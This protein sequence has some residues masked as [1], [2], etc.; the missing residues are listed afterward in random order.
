MIYS[1]PEANIERLNKKL[2]TIKNKCA[3][4]GCD[5]SWSE[6]GEEFKDV[7]DK[8]GNKFKTRFVLVDV[9]GTAIVNDWRFI[10]SVQH[11][12]KGNIITGVAGVEVPERYYTSAPYCEHCKTKRARK[13]AYI[14][15]N[16]KSGEFKQVG[17]SC[18]CDY[19][20]GLS[21][22]MAAQCLSYIPIMEKAA[23][24]YGGLGFQRY[25][26]T[27]E[28]LLYALETIKKF[29]YTKSNFNGVITTAQRTADFMSAANGG[30]VMQEYRNKCLRE[31]EQVN[32]VAH[33]P[34]NESRIEAALK[35]ISEQ[36]ENSNYIHNLRTVCSLDYVLR[37]NYGL[38][39]SLFPAYERA[40][41]DKQTEASWKSETEKS[42]YV[43]TVGDRITIDVASI[44]CALRWE[45]SFGIVS[46]YRMKDTL[47]NVYI[48]KTNKFLELEFIRR[49]TGTVK[50]HSEYK[51]AAQTEL[52]RCKVL[53]E[54]PV[55]D[56]PQ[57]GNKEPVCDMAYSENIFDLI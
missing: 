52:T 51:G 20:H 47:G 7:Q 29:G 15:Q 39:V 28:V 23:Q 42:E 45:S 8:N 26:E 21:A 25:E 19:T 41:N 27:R 34:E 2:H 24:I 4:Y 36:E 5:F 6:A 49:I 56:M 57:S 31:M 54:E 35:W 1:I 53:K 32:F 46:L 43:G 14:I 18:L 9:S 44:E 16:V 3:K 40:M 55:C 50:N 37:R 33:S 11:T 38:L 10:A 17:K 48:W 30:G 12:S 13:N 22:E